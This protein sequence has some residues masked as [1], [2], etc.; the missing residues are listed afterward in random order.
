MV[1]ISE[2]NVSMINWKIDIGDLE[3]NNTILLLKLSSAF[4][5]CLLFIPYTD[6]YKYPF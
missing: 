3:T 4:F 1:I 2:K 5:V 6:F